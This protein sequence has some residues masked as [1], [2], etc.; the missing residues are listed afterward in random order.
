MKGCMPPWTQPLHNPPPIIPILMTSQISGNTHFGGQ[1]VLLGSGFCR[2]LGTS[3]L[4]LH[5]VW[6]RRHYDTRPCP[7]VKLYLIWSEAE[8]PN[9]TLQLEYSRRDTIEEQRATS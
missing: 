1:N 4:W 2:V 8:A 6:N 3:Q 5:A 9:I 7:F